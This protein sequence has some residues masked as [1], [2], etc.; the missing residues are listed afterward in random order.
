MPGS[1]LG[2]EL[3]CEL[4]DFAQGDLIDRALNIGVKRVSIDV[5]FGIHR[6]LQADS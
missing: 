3:V 2:F 6:R 5:R 4:P 1:L